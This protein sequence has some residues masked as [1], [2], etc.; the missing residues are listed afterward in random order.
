M[1]RPRSEKHVSNPNWHAIEAQ[2]HYT[3]ESRSPAPALG[4]IGPPRVRA[5]VFTPLREALRVGT[6]QPPGDPSYPP[7]EP[8]YTPKDREELIC[9]DFILAEIA[10][11]TDRGLIP[12]VSRDTIACET[13]ARR[14]AIERRGRLETAMQSA[15]NL[16]ASNPDAALR[17]VAEACALDPQ[18]AAAWT[19]AISLNRRLQHDREA[20]AA[21]EQ[22][23]SHIA[24]F[25]ITPVIL[26]DEF[27][28]RDSAANRLVEAQAA[29]QR[30][31]DATVVRHCEAILADQPDHFD[32]L[33][34]LAFVA[35]KSERLEQA[36]TLYQR[37]IAAQ[38]DRPVWRQWLE[39]VERRIAQRAA[40]VPPAQPTPP[41]FEAPAVAFLPDRAPEPA[42]PRLSLS[43]IA[44]EFLQDHWQK[45]IL[46]LAVLLVVVSSN[47]GAYQVLGPRLWSPVG[48]CLLALVYTAMFAALGAGLVRWGA[49][50]AGR[51]MLLTT[52]IV[53]PA[54]FMLAGQM[55]LLTEPT[56]SGLTMLAVDALALLLLVRM[57]ARSLQLP[58][59]AGFLSIALFVLSAINSAAAPEAWWPWSWQ[60]AVFL[61][62][63]FVF[64]GAVA[65]VSHRMV[66]RKD[67]A[68]REAV[69][70]AL[71]LLAFTYVTGVARTGVFV[72]DL[73]PALYA[74]PTM[75]GALACAIAA[76]GLRRVDDK[77]HHSAWLSFAGLV[78]TALAVALAL[79][80][81]QRTAL[82][83]GNALAVALLGLGLFVAELVIERHPAYLYCGFGALGLA[84]YSLDYFIHDA[85]QASK[86]AV[87]TAIGLK[88]HL[89]PPYKALDGWFL[90]IALAVLALLFHR[91]WNSPRL[92]RHCH[93]IGVPFSIA[94]C[95]FSGLDPHAA[96]ICLSGYAVL[97]SV[98][99]GV[100]REPRVIYLACAA[101]AAAVD[102]GLGL[103]PGI[104]L[105]DRSLG[106]AFL[107]LG[108]GG[109]AA[110]LRR[111]SVDLAYRRPFDRSSLG[112][113]L[114]ALAGAVAA[115][116]LPPTEL[117]F[118]AGG[119]FLVVGLL[120]ILVNRDE[121]ARWLGYAAVCVI[122]IG[123]I[124]SV[125]RAGNL[126]LGGLTLG[127][128]AVAAGVIGFLS[129]VARLL[130]S[131]FAT[132]DLQTNR[133]AAYPRP[134]VDT[135]LILV[136]IALVASGLFVAQRQPQLQT[137]DFATLAVGLG[138]VTTT[139]ML[140]VALRH[141]T[142]LAY[143]ALASGLGTWISVC[144]FAHGQQYHEAA[145]FALIAMIYALLLL[146]IEELTHGRMARIAAGDSP[147]PRFLAPMEHTFVQALPLFEVATVWSAVFLA[148]G[149]LRNGPAFI[150]SSTMGA[151]VMFGSTRLRPVMRLVAFGLTLTLLAGW[152]ATAWGVGWNDIGRTFAW[153]ALT[154]AG[155]SAVFLA[156]SLLAWRLGDRTVYP[157]P[158]LWF[159]EQVATFVM[160]LTLASHFTSLSAYGLRGGALG[161][162][163]LVLL[164]VAWVRRQP[165][166]T[167]RALASIILGV[168]LVELG[169]IGI[170]PIPRDLPGVTGAI[171]ALVFQAAGLWLRE[172][173]ADET[174]SL[175]DRVYVMPLLNTALFLSIVV[176]P[177]GYN[178]AWTMGLVGLSFLVMVKTL[179]SRH[180]LHAAL[181]AWL[182]AIHFRLIQDWPISRWT[183]TYLG[184]A[185]GL[186]LLGMVVRR[187]EPW[188]I[189]RL[190]LNESRYADPIFNVA[191]VVA[192]LAC[193]WKVHARFDRPF[194]WS[195]WTGP[196]VSLGGFCVLMI[197]AYPSTA[198]MNGAV[199]LITLAACAW[200]DPALHSAYAWLPLLLGMACVWRIVGRLVGPRREAVCKWAGIPNLEYLGVVRLWAHAL[201][202]VT[203]FL[204][205]CVV[206][207]MVL[208]VL[209]EAPTYLLAASDRWNAVMLALG[210][211]AVYLG[212][213]WKAGRE[214]E[215]GIGLSLLATEAAWWLVAPDSPLVL[216]WELT[217]LRA[218]PITTA[219]I[220]AGAIL[221][222]LLGTR[223]PDGRQLPGMLEDNDAR[224]RFDIFLAGYG[225]VLAT[226]AGLMTRGEDGL[227]PLTTYTIAA[228]ATVTL[229]TLRRSVAAGYFSGLLLLPV[230]CLA[231]FEITRRF[232]GATS[233]D[234]RLFAWLGVL[235]SIGALWGLSGWMRRAPED[236]KRGERVAR[237][238]EQLAFAAGILL[239]LGVLE[240]ALVRSR[241]SDRGAL[242]AVGELFGVALLSV[243]LVF[244]WQNAR[245]IYVAQGATLVAYLYYRW[246][247]P[248]PAT[249]DAVILTLF[250][251]LDLG[252]AEVLS[253]AGLAGHARPTRQI[254]L[255]LPLVPLALCLGGTRL[256][257]Q[258]LFILFASATFYGIACYSLQWRWL[259]HAATLLYN[260]FLWV[261]W[262]RFGW[263][264]ADHVPYFLVPVGLTAVL[265]AEANRRALGR[266]A[267]NAIRGVGLSI[268]YLSL[269]T[270][271]WQFDSFGA[272]LT[273]LFV[274]LAGI[275]AG[276]GLRVQVFLWLGLSCFLLDLVYQLGKM[277]RDYSMARWAIMLAVGLL[278]FLFVALNEKK[279]LVTR[280]R[281]GFET[282]RDWE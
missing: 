141:S 230:G 66:A 158:C 116:V 269:A 229:A 36:R 212:V 100:F 11:W 101:L 64:L 131:P 133:L 129:M 118:A 154:S 39:N 266:A 22:A 176:V 28:T 138:L 3:P 21:A 55:K 254:S 278:L 113:A 12:E 52:L 26:R 184:I 175:W 92:A 262:G 56:A 161:G 202:G 104:T 180:W 29:L 264:L 178:S 60:F 81:S 78:L 132:S 51:I 88:P 257:E 76:R 222:C 194:P 14:D 277:G 185:Y 142:A 147:S 152:S 260:A 125:L 280:M 197:A 231:A 91:R 73:E 53:V 121:P 265:F 190:R 69:L 246:A 220:A 20:I 48:K 70:F 106:A 105:S 181:A 126:W 94:A 218:L 232:G 47:V 238:W 46:C 162:S 124:L 261:L 189:A 236:R 82:S 87:L 5:F 210:L 201:F 111:R 49:V 98:A 86:I 243:G 19:L 62:P 275:F 271:I 30:G 156:A 10:Q 120:V 38:P 155:L 139:L 58:D 228:L 282:A 256:S 59:G 263:R 211:S 34:L 57:V 72:L 186:W 239:M 214:V 140:L 188:L 144:N 216:R 177:F 96:V 200:I 122:Q 207:G 217:P 37:L 79:V 272:W 119:A 166:P 203:S 196:L 71:A 153:L 112:L 89:T 45:L 244:R 233:L 4:P 226:V 135:S 270:P 114:L 145:S 75:L 130:L 276:I 54:N 123:L 108:L 241:P 23:C 32:A 65:W 33:V 61:A 172:T 17:W 31:D 143:L 242:A 117:T 221:G 235:G 68:A 225:L 99:V 223:R 18:N 192:P 215:C 258:S 136:A 219:V 259:G 183:W 25:P 205:A 83:S 8:T 253:R 245:L 237:A 146:A 150:A 137:D 127:Q 193:V 43:G 149:G 163:G 95:A 169:R 281:K 85:V 273:L 279:G 80:Q 234:E 179:A 191:A 247:F 50:R 110:V 41:P 171:L 103:K 148:I 9:L 168:A 27:A 187:F 165:A 67:D 102:F 16:A 1:R 248:L 40:S 2:R 115:V 24:D 174:R 199:G 267:V 44:S 84:Y 252:L 7:I 13:Q 164:A 42:P 35:Q 240:T 128:L 159:A 170:R 204:A 107:A 224:S 198:W 90:N 274:S 206:L 255:I 209:N 250:G 213:S 173:R 109:I 74:V 249:T 167:Y 227:G 268:V 15:R 97:Y 134:L 157:G 208:E 93:Y 182:F 63:G 6:M 77:P 195:D 160:A 151:V 251:Y